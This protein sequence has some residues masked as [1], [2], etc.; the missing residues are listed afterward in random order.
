MSQLLGLPAELVAS[1]FQHLDD[2]DFF[3]T[4]LSSRY[5]E[6]SASTIFGKRFFRKKGF[7][8]TTPSLD[9]LESIARSENLSKYVQ[10]IW[11]NPDCYTFIE[12]ACAPEDDLDCDDAENEDEDDR[13]E[14]TQRVDLLSTK[15]KARWNAYC[16]CMTDHF[17]LVHPDSVSSRPEQLISRLSATC[18]LLPNLKIIGMRRS[19]DHCPWG[20]RSLA[21]SV[22]EDPRVIGPIPSWPS[23]VLSGPTMLF[24]AIN[25][26]VAASGIG[27][28]RQ[29]TDA[30]EIDSVPNHAL[31]QATVDTA[32]RSMLYLEINIS[33]AWNTIEASPHLRGLRDPNEYGDGLLKV[34]RA[35][36]PTLLELGLQI[37]P[38]LR[39]TLTNTI[40][41]SRADD[42]RRDYQ[43]L[44]FRKVADNVRFESLTR[45][46]LEKIITTPRTLKT[47]LA[48]SHSRL[49][50]LKLRDIR[51]LPNHEDDDIRADR[52]WGEVFAFLHRSCSNITYL[53]LHHLLYGRGGI[54]F[55]SE[56]AQGESVVVEHTPEDTRVGTFKDYSDISLELVGRGE[57]E[58]RLAALVDEH[59]YLG[60]VYSYAMDEEMWHTDTSDEEW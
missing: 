2:A 35:A 14:I 37:F 32:L 26:A 9:V 15:D 51:L 53:L 27:L 16:E 1:I 3:A 52:P 46:K 31:P 28:K 22:G 12:P 5:L 58:S 20:W 41:L 50:S 54:A 25:H 7:M 21:D 34:L 42:M 17:S 23:S 24:V 57:V 44:G 11:F 19:E 30:L 33:K 49:T 8:I 47:F 6:R 60:N 48:P 38:D 13:I 45:V 56:S 36:A 4:R 29:Y 40:G 18:S 43:F 55:V 59:Y 10:H 39:S